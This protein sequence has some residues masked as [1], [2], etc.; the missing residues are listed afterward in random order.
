MLTS[1]TGSSTAGRRRSSYSTFPVSVGRI[2][3]RSQSFVRVTFIGDELRD[4]GTAG[5]DQ[6]IKVVVPLP[7][8]GVTAFPGG[9][10]WYASWRDLP[11]R[12]RNPIRTYTI[13]GIRPKLRE[14]DV[15]FVLH[16]DGG[17]ASR[18]VAAACAG[19][20]LAIVG[21]HAEAEDSLSGVE[22]RPGDARTVLLAGDETAKPAICSILAALPP[23]TQ[24]CAFIEVPYSDDCEAVAAPAGVAVTW[25]ARADTQTD[26]GEAVSNAV[27]EW[28]ARHLADRLAP[29]AETKVEADPNADSDIDG[30]ILWEVP[31][32]RPVGDELFAWLAGEAGIIKA[33]RRF[34]VTE[35]GIDRRQVAFMGYW[36]AGRPELG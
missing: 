9:P 18:W 23:E 22:W 28:T 2:E 15:D 6:R 11:G 1:I 27:R 10:D 34:L 32:Q 31:Q 17:P 25:L 16:G 30:G 12:L 24:G 19:D 3:R 4:F 8:L 14:L 35:A 5:L 36:R 26:R 21:P 29:K 33:L 20:E 13:R 7:G